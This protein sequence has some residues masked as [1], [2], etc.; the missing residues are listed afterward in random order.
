MAINIFCMELGGEYRFE[1]ILR[2]SSEYN[3][4]LKYCTCRYDGEVARG[5]KEKFPDAIIHDSYDA[6]LGIPPIKYRDLDLV[7]LDQPFLQEML[8]CESIV[9]RMMDRIDPKSTFNF[10][11]RIR[12]YYYYLKY[13]LTIL[14]IHNPEVV[15]F[16]SMPHLIYDYV[17][18]ALC[19]KRGI[20]T[21][22][23]GF[24]SFSH[25]CVPMQ[26]ISEK[27]P[28]AVLYDKL[29]KDDK[30]YQFSLSPEVQDYIE[31]NRRAEYSDVVAPSMVFLD[32]HLKSFY[33]LN[34]SFLYKVYDFLKDMRMMA[35]S[36]HR[37]ARRTMFKI[38]CKRGKESPFVSCF[39]YQL[40]K[41]RGKIKKISLFRYYNKLV[42]K[43]DLAKPYLY[44][45][46]AYQPELTTSP[47]GDLFV[48]QLLMVELLSR[49]IPDG[50]S[51]YVKEHPHQFLPR[52]YG[53][54]SRSFEFYDDLQR[55]VNVRLIPADTS[56]FGLIDNAKA[57]ATITSNT[58]FEAIVR[59]TPVLTFGHAWYNGCEGV[60]YVQTSEECKETFRNI[61]NGYT[62]NNDK[63]KLFMYA[64]EKTSMKALLYS[65]VKGVVK[66][67][68]EENVRAFT[69]SLQKIC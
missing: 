66:I 1:A 57:V 52:F 65:K 32:K 28:A 19:Q 60:F 29:L 27:S 22:A 55:L 35:G 40:F 18:Y 30:S 33:N 5:V 6:V 44:V 48:N 69:D 56:P 13:W 63:V 62:I 36:I 25:L 10:N 24:T 11:K 67:S 3:W 37:P 31:I 38:N 42:V 59:G 15:I 23:Y 49:A 68:Y 46:L 64:L 20:E 2:M 43:P 26:S 14:N 12:L 17:L 61:Q 21:M 58:G 51:I 53:E 41:Y 9:L 54:S 7:S 47:L 45:A 50:W 16:N 4:S 8:F 34:N 39:K